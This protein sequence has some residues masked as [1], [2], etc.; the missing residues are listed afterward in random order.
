VWDERNR[1]VHGKETMRASTKVR[2]QLQKQVELEY[3][4]YRKDKFIIS[5]NRSHIFESR[6]VKQWMN[7][8]D[9]GIRCWL[10][11]VLEAKETQAKSGASSKDI[12]LS[13]T[14]HEY[15]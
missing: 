7:Q 10:S 5:Q 8:D 14:Q 9:D 4:S 1:V 11:D 15:Y 13:K 6:T 3:E 12:F 2:K